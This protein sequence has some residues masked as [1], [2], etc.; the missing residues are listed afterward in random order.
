MSVKIPDALRRFESSTSQILVCSFTRSIC[1]CY[2]SKT[3]VCSC[4]YVDSLLFIVFVVLSGRDGDTKS[5]PALQFCIAVISVITNSHSVYF[6]E[7]W[8]KL[9]IPIPYPPGKVEPNFNSYSLC[10]MEYWKKFRIPFNSVHRAHKRNA[11]CTHKRTTH[12]RNTDDGIPKYD[13]K[14]IITQKFN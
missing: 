5:V 14:K 11:Q 7:P 3:F 6:T 13:I 9:K 10:S 1:V 12:Q 8:I 4:F 2:C